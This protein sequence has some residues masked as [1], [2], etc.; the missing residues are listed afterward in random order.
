MR[1]G[2]EAMVVGNVAV[3][4]RAEP[5]GMPYNVGLALNTTRSAPT[6]G[7]RRSVSGSG[8]WFAVIPASVIF[9]HMSTARPVEK[10]SMICSSVIRKVLRSSSCFFFLLS[11]ICF[12]CSLTSEDFRILNFWPFPPNREPEYTLIARV[13]SFFVRFKTT[14]RHGGRESTS[15]RTKWRSKVT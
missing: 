11:S 12:F 13:T 2:T 5:R 6:R 9:W 14:G 10:R 3:L 8:S 7:S 4:I 1:S 15:V